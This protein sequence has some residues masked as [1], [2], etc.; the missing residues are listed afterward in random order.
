MVSDNF[1]AD[2]LSIGVGACAD[3]AAEQASTKALSMAGAYTAL[4]PKEKGRKIAL[5]ALR[6]FGPEASSGGFP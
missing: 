3:A 6:L 1:V 2:S 4:L 5:P